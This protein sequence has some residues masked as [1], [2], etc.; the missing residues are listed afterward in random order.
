MFFL[1]ALNHPAH[2]YLF[3]NFRNEMIRKGNRVIFIIKEKE[4]LSTLLDVEGISYVKLL[5]NQKLRNRNRFSILKSSI[6]ELVKADFNLYKYVIAN[7][8]DFLLGTDVSIS[9]IGKLTH[10]PSFIFNEDDIEINKLFCYSSYPF[11]KYI[12]SPEICVVGKYRTK[13]VGYNGYQKLAYLHPNWFT[14]KK[15]VLS[16][17][18]KENSKNFIIR[19]V[20]FTAGHDIEHSHSGITASLLDTLIERLSNIGNVY[21]SS[22]REIPEKYLGYKLEIKINDIHHYIASSTLFISDSQSMTVEACMLGTPSLRFNSFAGRISVLNEL[23]N[24]YLLTSSFSPSKEIQFL[25]KLDKMLNNNDL[26]LIYKERQQ[27]MLKEKIDLTAFLIWLFENYPK[28][29]LEFK[30]KPYLQYQFK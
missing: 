17:S 19:L 8:P 5:T 21:I 7:K 9:Q 4:I 24:K 10:V 27:T 13:K 12:V 3:K 23:E 11:A 16:S 1:I 25:E 6:T 22:E 14:P 30:N 2:Y 20:A 29:L 15:G 26:K 28:N 18:F